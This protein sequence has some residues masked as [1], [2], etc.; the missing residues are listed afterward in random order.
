MAMVQTCPGPS[1]VVR[2][3]WQNVT[4]DTDV[5]DLVSR[6]SYSSWRP[7]SVDE[8]RGFS[9][10][11]SFWVMMRHGVDEMEPIFGFIASLILESLSSSYRKVKVDIELL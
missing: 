11:L 6:A 2:L 4:L 1:L 9:R 7:M 8:I 10:L 5:C 3:L